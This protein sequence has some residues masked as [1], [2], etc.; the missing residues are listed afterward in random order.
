MGVGL[1]GQ[2]LKQ[3][4]FAVHGIGDIALLVQS[5][6]EVLQFENQRPVSSGKGSGNNYPDL[7]VPPVHPARQNCEGQLRLFCRRH[8]ELEQKPGAICIAA[9]GFPLQQCR[10]IF[11]PGNS[12]VNK[13]AAQRF[14]CG[15]NIVEFIVLMP[16]GSFK[17][18]AY[19][20]RIAV[21]KRNFLGLQVCFQFTDIIGRNIGR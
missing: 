5:V 15:K 1:S 18:R 9:E 16:V 13:F 4:V 21:Q 11:P 10:K 2:Q 7:M 19:R 12:F 20:T 14:H 8:G 3:F 17:K 6:K